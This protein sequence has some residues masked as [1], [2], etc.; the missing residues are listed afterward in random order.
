MGIA[1]YGWCLDA[2]GVNI[3]IEA[4]L[5]SGVKVIS[6]TDGGYSCNDHRFHVFGVADDKRQVQQ[7]K[8]KI[9]KSSSDHG[10]DFQE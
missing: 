10:F 1:C 4:M 6:V 9:V 3:I 8:D 7:T 2:D 5:E